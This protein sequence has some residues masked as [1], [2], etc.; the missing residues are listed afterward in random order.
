MRIGPLTIAEWSHNGSCRIWLSGNES[1]PKLYK[2]TYSRHEL[3][4][5]DDFSKPHMGSE[6]GSWQGA[7]ARWI[8]DQT[9]ISVPRR[10]YMP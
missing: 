4:T 8:E 9:G 6:R 7:I 1:A 5:G 2:P 10:A 3:M